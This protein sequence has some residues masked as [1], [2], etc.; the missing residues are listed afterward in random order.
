MT[1]NVELGPKPLWARPG[2]WSAGAVPALGGE[3]R[4]RISRAE[5]TAISLRGAL[6]G[7][8]ASPEL[9]LG[10]TLVAGE[11]VGMKRE[12]GEVALALRPPRRSPSAKVRAESVGHTHQDRAAG[13]ML[14][15]QGG[16]WRADW[17]AQVWAAPK[18]A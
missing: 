18:A 1:E 16:P 3:R 14:G 2:L 8:T 5:A 10:E 17:R 12:A 15:E 9:A 4:K 13:R 7:L 11:T 6:Y